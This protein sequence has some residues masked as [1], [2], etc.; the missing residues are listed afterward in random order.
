MTDYDLNSLCLLTQQRHEQR[1]REAGAE[2]LARALR[3]TPQRR[4]WLLVR[5]KSRLDPRAFG[6]RTQARQ[7]VSGDQAVTR[8]TFASSGRP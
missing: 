1:L 7:S 6:R 8:N 3:H 2:R 5:I 4:W